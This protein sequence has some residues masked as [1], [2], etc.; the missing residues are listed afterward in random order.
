MA[1]C[2]VT[3]TWF[4]TERSLNPE[5]RARA[6]ER[7]DATPR[8]LA[9]T[10]RLLDTRHPAFRAVSAVRHR[11]ES[12]WR[13]TTLPFPEP[14]VRL[15]RLDQVDEFCRRMSAYSFELGDV[16]AALER[17]FDELKADAAR[18]LGS[19]FDPSDYPASLLDAFRVKCDFP[20]VEPPA[21][22]AW[23]SPAAYQAEAYRVEARYEEA[24]R[25]AERTF[26]DDFTRLVGHLCERLSGTNPDGTARIF[27][28]AAVD[29]LGAFIDRYRWL[30]LRSDPQLDELI[31]LA[32]RTLVGVTP[33]RLRDHPGL[34][35]T[36]ATQLSWVVASLDAMRGDGMR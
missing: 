9:A 16:V 17:R 7:F 20:G 8:S 13:V 30:G 22:L 35:R 14:C 19:L 6:A 27:R 12:D 21:N 34:K 29:D 33:R 15:I 23:L 32:R 10:K 5:Q 3:L 26:L 11:I 24:V 2:R 1:P 28:D 4:C 36:V 25:L 31:G 18:R